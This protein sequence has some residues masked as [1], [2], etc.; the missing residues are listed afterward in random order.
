MSDDEKAHEGSSR[1]NGKGASENGKMRGNGSSAPEY[2][3][4]DHIEYPCRF[5]IKA[6]GKHSNRF[7]ALVQNIVSKHTASEDMLAAQSRP[8]RRGNYVSITC[9]IRA[10]NKAQI[11]A[12]YADLSACPD[13]LMTL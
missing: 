13:V 10:R 4:F 8:S 9:I 11:R 1:G 6:M 2:D 5:E 7:A 12:I 3:P